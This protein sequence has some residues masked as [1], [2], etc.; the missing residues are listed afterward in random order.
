MHTDV[1]ILYQ[2]WHAAQVHLLDY[3]HD[4]SMNHI[5]LTVSIGIK[6]RMAGCGVRW[7]SGTKKDYETREICGGMKAL[8]S[9]RNQTPT[10]RVECR[11]TAVHYFVLL[12]LCFSFVSRSF[13]CFMFASALSFAYPVHSGTIK[14]EFRSAKKNEQKIRWAILVNPGG[15][16]KMLA[17]VK[18][19][20]HRRRINL[21]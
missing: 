3:I 11:E 16:G 15:L 1:A 4:D 20:K 5:R 2:N 13:L 19:R 21:S 7:D 6:Q 18:H 12:P 8:Q 9:L 14:L 17:W 10:K